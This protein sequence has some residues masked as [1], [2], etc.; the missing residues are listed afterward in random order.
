[1]NGELLETE[2]LQQ[3]G[4]VS[5]NN[6]LEILKETDVEEQEINILGPSKYVDLDSITSFIK[7]NKDNFTIF[8]VNIQSLNAKFEELSTMIKY[9]RE[10]FKFNFSAICLQECWLD[11]ETD[12]S[13]FKIPNY[14][15]IPQ[16]KQC[17][18]H[19]GLVTYIHEEFKGKVRSLFKKSKER[20]WEGQCI[21]VTGE[22]LKSKVT[23]S[24]IYRPP[25]LNNN[26]ATLKSFISELIPYLNILES[27]KNRNIILGDFN[28]DLLQ[29]QHRAIIEEFYDKFVSMGF[30]PRITLPTRFSTKSCT[31]I[32]QI[33]CNFENPAQICTSAI[34]TS[35]LSDHLPCLLGFEITP[36]IHK[37]PK[38]ITKIDTSEE[39]TQNFIKGIEHEL[40]TNSLNESQNVDPNE[41]Y[42]QLDDILQKCH[43][44]YFPVKT[45]RFNKYVHKI[46]PWVTTE[47]LNTIKRRDKLYVQ[48]KKT[49]H[50]TEEYNVLKRNL[51]TINNII[52][53]TNRENKREHF[54]ATF[55]K[56][57]GDCKKTW[58]TISS[59]LN[60][61]TK[62]RT[63]PNIS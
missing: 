20:L 23:I 60:K 63:F 48:L 16:G 24:N 42:N 33:F 10:N 1:M 52:R 15:L 35:K 46:N 21:T 6:L 9:F 30:L 17:C 59:V 31:L 54:H 53:K 61:S 41:S 28:I 43:K 26:N 12:T 47:T 56:Y 19:G 4:G 11:D 51:S 7:N 49:K 45:I 36:K 13:Q 29:L 44:K 55:S 5:A 62:K 27:E 25:K 2:L 14:N 38:F 3:F 32:D 50:D 8:S 37:K 40:M 34:L 39:N 57:S 22:R 58:A 18:H